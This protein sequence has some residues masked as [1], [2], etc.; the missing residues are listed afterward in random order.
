MFKKAQV[1]VNQVIQTIIDKYWLLTKKEKWT[2]DEAAS[3]IGCSR[4]H[5]SKIFND[6]R[7]PS[8]ALLEAMERVL[9]EYEL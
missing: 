1:K 5:L 4:S 7:K 2:Q 3:Y 6:K 9:K 8:M